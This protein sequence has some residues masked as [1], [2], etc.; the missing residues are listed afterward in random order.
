MQEVVL[1]ELALAGL[2]IL[3]MFTHAAYFACLR[4][5]LLTLVKI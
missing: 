4:L 1:S 3:M 5:R 2:L